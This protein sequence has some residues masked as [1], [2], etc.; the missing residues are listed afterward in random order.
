MIQVIDDHGNVHRYDEGTWETDDVT[1]ELTVKT[2]Q[3]AACFASGKWVC[4]EQERP[5]DA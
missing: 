3:K 2:P 1:G 5:T 4:I